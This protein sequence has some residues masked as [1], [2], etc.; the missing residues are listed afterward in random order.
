MTYVVFGSIRSFPEKFPS[1]VTSMTSIR[2]TSSRSRRLPRP[3][4]R[5]E[6]RALDNR[7]SERSAVA[8]RVAARQHQPCACSS[9][10]SRSPTGR[11]AGARGLGNAEHIASGASPQQSRATEYGDSTGPFPQARE[12]RRERTWI[13]PMRLIRIQPRPIQNDRG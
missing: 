7:G 4:A 5:T 6:T 3:A 10:A 1:T 2:A 12:T 13:I 9:Y 11:D 8:R